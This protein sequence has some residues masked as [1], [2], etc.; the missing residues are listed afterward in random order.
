VSDSVVLFIDYQNTYRAARAV[1][2]E[3]LDHHVHGQINPRR[4][5]DLILTKSAAP[6]KLKEVRIYRGLP[7]SK[8]DSKGY[9]AARSQIATWDRDPLVRP[10]WRP[11]RYPE[12]WP[13]S[14]EEEKGIDVQIAVDY[15]MGAVKGD[16]DVGILMSLDT[17]MKPA[18]ETVRDTFGG[19][20]KT[21]VAAWNVPQRH[22]RKLSVK[23]VW[24]HWLQPEDYA[25]V[26]E[27]HDYNTGAP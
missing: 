8:H 6:R 25:A 3:R 16:F 26:Q 24:C 23:G 20:V 5:G 21:E 19:R 7:S 22:C 27:L 4:L 9:A 14:P 18:L 17:D 12:D 13:N 1:Y 15:V 11:L 10:I 2:H